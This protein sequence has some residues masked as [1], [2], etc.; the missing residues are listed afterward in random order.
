MAKAAFGEMAEALL[1][2]SCRVR[3]SKLQES[4]YEFAFPD[5]DGVLRNYLGRNET[6]SEE[7]TGVLR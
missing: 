2:C 5:L 3:P 6:V 1:L 7:L 4:K